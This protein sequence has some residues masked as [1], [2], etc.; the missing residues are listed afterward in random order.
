MGKIIKSNCRV[1]MRNIYI[2]IS[3]LKSLQGYLHLA[4]YHV[5]TSV[6]PYDYWPMIDHSS[7]GLNYLIDRVI[8]NKKF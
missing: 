1:V 7:L 3:M 5:L 8:I 2:H 4:R 6:S